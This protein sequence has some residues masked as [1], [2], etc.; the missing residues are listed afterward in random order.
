MPG[1]IIDDYKGNSKEVIKLYYQDINLLRGMLLSR[2]I[3][4]PGGSPHNVLF[5]LSIRSHKLIS[6]QE[7]SR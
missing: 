1:I 5:V 3:H 4:F 7:L 2:S 6:P